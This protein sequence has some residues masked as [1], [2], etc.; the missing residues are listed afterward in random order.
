[1]ISRRKGPVRYGQRLCH[2]AMVFL[3]GAAAC[4]SGP[5]GPGTLE[6]R[7]QADALGAAVLEVEGGGIQ[8]FVGRGSTQVYSGAVPGRAGVHRVIVVDPVGGDIVFEVEVDDVR[9]DGP[10]VTVVKAANTGNVPMS[11]SGVTVRIER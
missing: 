9:M 8:G 3:L 4:D 6:A 10:I 7:V 11:V 1:M 5:S 2:V